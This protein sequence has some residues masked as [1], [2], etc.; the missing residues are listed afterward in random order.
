MFKMSLLDMVQDIMSDMSSDEVNSIEDTSESLQVATIIKNAYKAMLSSRDWPHLNRLIQ[1]ES[2]VS[3]D[4]PTYL[5]MPENVKRIN[6][7]QYDTRKESDNGKKLYKSIR[8]LLPNEFLD[9]TNL[10]DSTKSNVTVSLDPNVGVEVM[11]LN[12]TAPQYWTTFDDNYI[13]FDA[14]DSNM[15]SVVQA[16]KCQVSAYVLPEF[17]MDDDYVPDLPAEAFPALLS[18]ARSQA[19]Y[20]LNQ[21]TDPISEAERRRQQRWLSRNSRRSEDVNHSPNYGRRARKSGYI[22]PLDKNSGIK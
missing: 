22:T 5:I 16:S 8:G 14:Y 15:D 10:R 6:S 19:M 3:T 21:I 12:D 20:W 1:L 9:K 17:E 13:V 11:V 18:K 4:R 7:I 2:A